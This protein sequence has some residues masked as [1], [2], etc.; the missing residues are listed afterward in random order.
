MELAL[1]VTL[2]S[3]TWATGPGGREPCKA[4]VMRHK[5]AK[6]VSPF[7]EFHQRRC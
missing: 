7:S 1:S 4:E 5:R 2:Q 6:V 3:V